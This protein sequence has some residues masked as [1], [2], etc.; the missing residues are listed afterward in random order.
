MNCFISWWKF[1]RPKLQWQQSNDGGATELSKCNTRAEQHM[2][3][4]ATIASII[5]NLLNFSFFHLHIC[6]HHWLVLL[7]SFLPLFFFLRHF[8]LPICTKQIFGRFFSFAFGRFCVWD[9]INIRLWLEEQIHAIKDKIMPE[10]EKK[11]SKC[12]WWWAIIK[13][14]MSYWN[15]SDFCS[16]SDRA[17][18]LTQFFI[19]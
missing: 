13:M 3:K 2:G 15:H 12:Y 11:Y 7:S 9:C 18:T 19:N 6:S 1:N 4:A 14:V 17:I 8:S 5:M 16:N 10:K